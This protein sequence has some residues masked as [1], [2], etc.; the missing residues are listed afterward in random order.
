MV[1]VGDAGDVF[2]GQLAVGAIGIMRPILRASMNR[3]SPR[4]ITQV[5]LHLRRADSE[6]GTTDT[7]VSEST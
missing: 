5:R 7:P 1:C 3:I 4:L 2:G 6:R